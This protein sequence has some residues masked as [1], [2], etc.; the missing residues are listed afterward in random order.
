MPSVIATWRPTRRA[1]GLAAGQASAAAWLAACGVGGNEPPKAGSTQPVE[2]SIWRGVSA[3]QGRAWTRLADDWHAREPKTQ[4]RIEELQ[5]D[6]RTKFTAAV[7][8][9]TTPDIGFELG[10]GTQ[11][12]FAQG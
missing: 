3:V 9:G 2:L 8:A 11:I 6:W 5:E 4:L 10:S 12:K 1:L 7:A